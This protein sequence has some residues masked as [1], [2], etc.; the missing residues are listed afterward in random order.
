MI[1]CVYHHVPSL[2]FWHTHTKSV[3]KFWANLVTAVS[4]LLLSTA[5]R[6]SMSHR[7]HHTGP[8]L[9]Q[10]PCLPCWWTQTRVKP[11]ARRNHRLAST[12]L[13]AVHAVHGVF[14]GYIW[15]Y[16]QYFT[17]FLL[18]L[19]LWPLSLK[20]YTELPVLERLGNGWRYGRCPRAWAINRYW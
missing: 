6:P 8:Q 17:C 7:W 16:F 2:P 10:V 9:L 19:Q 1:F 15:L 4:S 13:W 14:M 20:L 11:V 12:I 3:L 18:T 5:R